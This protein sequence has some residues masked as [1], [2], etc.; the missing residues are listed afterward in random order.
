MW[1]LSIQKSKMQKLAKTNF[2]SFQ[3][4][5]QTISVRISKV[6]YCKRRS[7]KLFCTVCVSW[8]ELCPVNQ[9]VK[10]LISSQDIHLGCGFSPSLGYA[11]CNGRSPALQQHITTIRPYFLF[12]LCVCCGETRSLLHSS[13]PWL[14]QADGATN[15]WRVAAVTM[16]YKKGDRQIMCWLLKLQPRNESLLCTFLWLK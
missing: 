3:H 2:K 12:T 5:I 14:I 11:R 6:L 4:N 8:L 15:I 1:P 10:G 13:L 7:P 16:A 9:K